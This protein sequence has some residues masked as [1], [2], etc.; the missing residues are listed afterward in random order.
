MLVGEA[1]E[2]L[3]LVAVGL[4]V[5]QGVAVE[6]HAALRVV[7]LQEVGLGLAALGPRPAHEPLLELDV[8]HLAL[9]LGFRLRLLA[10]E[11]LGRLAAHHGV[12]DGVGVLFVVVAGLAD[13]ALEVDAGPLLDH[14]GGLVGRGVEIRRAAEG[15]VVA[16][17]EGGRA[18]AACRGGRRTIGVGLHAADV[19]VSERRLDLIE[20]RQRPAAAGDALG[21]ERAHVAAVLVAVALSLHR[22]LEDAVEER[23]VTRQPVRLWCLRRRVARQRPQR[24]LGPAALRWMAPVNVRLP[25]A[26]QKLSTW[27]RSLDPLVA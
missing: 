22:P 6:A 16:G 4:D 9:A 2:R 10:Q 18:H 26:F 15:D 19:V 8:L 13:A 23:L 7:L 3:L 17:G 25:G 20:E 1:L 5:A 14:V 24:R 21:G 27:A 11:L 12:G